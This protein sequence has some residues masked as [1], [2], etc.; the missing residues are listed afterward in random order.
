MDVLTQPRAEKQRVPPTTGPA[1]VATY[2]RPKPPLAEG[3][4]RDSDN[5]PT[6][7]AGA[8]GNLEEGA[9]KH[10]NHDTNSSR[11][12]GSGGS[13]GGSGGGGG[14]GGAEENSTPAVAVGKGEGGGAPDGDQKWELFEDDSADHTARF[15]GRKLV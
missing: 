8:S 9:A 2:F 6:A 10:E 7:P 11:A 15:R 3:V 14:G 5:G 13:E 4:H 1:P 12:A